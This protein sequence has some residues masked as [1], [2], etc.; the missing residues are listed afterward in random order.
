MFR[1]RLG[2]STKLAALFVLVLSVMPAQA[3]IGILFTGAG[4]INRSMGGAS[5]AAPIDASGA[6]YWNPAAISGLP[7]S[8][9]DLGV[10]LLYPQTR[11]GS[12]ITGLGAGSDRADN[13]VFAIPTM[14][15]VYQPCDS[16]FTYGLGVFTVGGFGVNYRTDP[17][18][19]I[20][21][22]Q[23]PFGVGVGPLDCFSGRSLS[24][25]SRWFLSDASSTGGA[26][27]SVAAPAVWGCSEL[28]AAGFASACGSLSA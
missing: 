13:G 14:A 11:L 8:S 1:L 10:E 24:V 6:L 2:L 20:L 3:Q 5:T 17:L 4:P 27:V 18:N 16:P 15:L 23:P 25:R 12:S 19:P 7:G 22:P 26:G 9:M 21:T 28:S